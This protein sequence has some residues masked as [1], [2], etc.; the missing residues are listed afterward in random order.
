MRRPRTVHQLH[1]LGDKL[2]VLGGK[3]RRFAEITHVGV[4][5]RH[6]RGVVLFLFRPGLVFVDAL[7]IDL[8]FTVRKGDR[9]K[10]EVRVGAQ[11]LVPV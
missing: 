4:D 5:P 8:E 9:V 6:H 2:R 3:V 10:E 7:V 11:T 1:S